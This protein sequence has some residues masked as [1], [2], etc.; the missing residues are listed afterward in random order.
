MAKKLSVDKIQDFLKVLCQN[1]KVV[2]PV[3]DNDAIYF[4][5]YT[6]ELELCLDRYTV[7]SPKEVLFPA[8]EPL[9]FFRYKKSGEDLSKVDVAVEAPPQIQ[10]RKTVVFGARPCDVS[11]LLTFDKVYIENGFKDPFYKARR[12]STLFIALTCDAPA[13]TCFCTSVGGSPAGTWGVD[14]LLT[15]VENEYVAE[16]CTG[17]GTSLLENSLMEQADYLDE[18]KADRIKESAKQKMKKVFS[19]DGVQ[20]GLQAVFSSDYW[21]KAAARCLNCGICTYVCPTCYCFNITDEGKE[22]AGE[23]IRSWDSCMFFLF[24]LEASGHNPRAQKCERFRNRFNHKYNYFVRRYGMISCVGCGRCV[25]YCPVSIDIREV[26][27]EAIGETKA[28]IK[29]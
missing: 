6:D 5:P 10:G 2:V 16:E 1:Y 3:K 15:K 23:R 4:T 29:I 12:E 20:E 9:L 21:K 19:A 14:V 24:T 17:E 8:T 18:K 27:R 13:N 22:Y 28:Q 7:L 11:G 26:V 25:K